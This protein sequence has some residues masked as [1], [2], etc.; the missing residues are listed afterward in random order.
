MARALV[1]L[2][3]AL[4]LL[5]ASDAAAGPPT[6][7][8]RGSIDLVLGLD[9][10][11]LLVAAE[12]H[13]ELRSLEQTLR[14]ANE[15]AAAL[16][17]SAVGATFGSTGRPVAISRLLVLRSTRSTREIARTFET[18]LR[19]AYPASTGDAVASLT[20]DRAP[21]PGAAVIWMSVEGRFV[22]LYKGPPRGVALGR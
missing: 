21:W 22:T 19:A 10:L 4:A 20:T 9:Y 13:S 7:Q 8:L 5:T 3:A 12:V 15:K 18:T 6:D 16:G 17:S 14:W 1:A 11:P 2:A